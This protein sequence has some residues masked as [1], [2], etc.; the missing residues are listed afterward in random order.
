MLENATTGAHAVQFYEAERF[1]HRAAASFLGPALRAGESAALI[2]R[3]R[4]LE[5]IAHHLSSSH[6]ISPEVM[7]RIVLVDA[8]ATL[9]TLMDGQTLNA[10]RLSAAFSDLVAQGRRRNDQGTFWIFGEMVDL[11]CKAGNHPA[12]LRLEEQWNVMSAGQAVATMCGYAI[13]DFDQD[14]H[15]TTF[16][17]ICRQHTHVFPT[18]T[19]TEAPD[20]RTRLAQIAFL[21][22]RARALAHQPAVVSGPGD[23]A[24]A[25][26]IYV[27]DDDASMRR[28]LARLLSA[29]DFHVQTFASAEEF[30]VAVA[31][32]SGGCLIADA[33]LV[34]MS[35][36]ELQR[37]MASANWRMPVIA[38]SGSHDQQIESEAVRLGASAFLSKPFDAQA[39]LDA[40]ARALTR[41]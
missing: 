24:A 37:R 20:D 19:F 12:A 11:L 38:M 34:G 7:G 36:S 40:I 22:Q 4:S 6:D 5:G 14:V 39:L 2:V 23:A 30:L 25:S 35:G 21:E 3:R 10:G 29:V 26:T 31:P 18:E 15:A 9:P 8:D 28:S 1:M 32:D 41:K 16:Q 17:A 13:Q 33:Q 27:I